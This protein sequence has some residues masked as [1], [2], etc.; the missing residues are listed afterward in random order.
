MRFP[1]LPLLGALAAAGCTIAAETTSGPARDVRPALTAACEHA[2]GITPAP[3]IPPGRPAFVHLAP[4]DF[5][6]LERAEAAL[7]SVLLR[8]DTVTYFSGVT[9]H[10]STYQRTDPAVPGMPVTVHYTEHL[11]PEPYYRSR[12]DGVVRDFHYRWGSGGSPPSAP[13]PAERLGGLLRR[14]E[15]IRAEVLEAFGPPMDSRPLTCAPCGESGLTMAHRSDLWLERGA[16]VQMDLVFDVPCVEAPQRHAD[17]RM[18]V[19]VYHD[20]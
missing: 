1:A 2:F 12:A 13:Q 10:E 5:G 15:A 17:Q 3:T 6:R 19:R 16:E 20:P 18:T 4:L 11:A 7:G 14:Y 9:R 8:R